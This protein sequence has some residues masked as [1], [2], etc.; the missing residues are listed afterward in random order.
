MSLFVRLVNMYVHVCM[1]NSVR[2]CFEYVYVYV[3][4]VKVAKA[5]RF[6]Q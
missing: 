2:V 5:R 6:V 4:M 1:Y 3:Y